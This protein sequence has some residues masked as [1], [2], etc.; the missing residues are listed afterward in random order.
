MGIVLHS[1]PA[2]DV[3]EGGLSSPTMAATTTTIP[4][5]P[6]YDTGNITI[7]RVGSWVGRRGEWAAL[8]V[9]GCDLSVTCVCL[10]FVFLIIFLFLLVSRLEHVHSELLQSAASCWCR[11]DMDA[12]MDV[13]ME[14]KHDGVLEKKSERSF[15]CLL[16]QMT[17]H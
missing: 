5:L 16:S 13:N 11:H 1:L 9:Q 10:Y 17:G 14:V 7:R 12:I 8:V 3:K 15:L 4:A 2:M 6:V